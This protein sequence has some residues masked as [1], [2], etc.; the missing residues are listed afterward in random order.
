MVDV[1]VV[2]LKISLAYTCRD[3]GKSQKTSVMIIVS[4][5]AEI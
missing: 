5:L 3:W 1:L 2:D 4:I